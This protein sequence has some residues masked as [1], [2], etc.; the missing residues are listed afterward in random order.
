M[1]SSRT[2]TNNSENFIAGLSAIYF[3]QILSSI[4]WK[5]FP[6]QMMKYVSNNYFVKQIFLIV[7]ILIS[8]EFLSED[9][10]APFSNKLTATLFLYL[11]VLIFPKQNL[12]FSMVESFLFFASFS[13]YYYD[14]RD[15][16]SGRD[17]ILK[18][19]VLIFLIVLVMG[20][21]FYYLKQKR[22][23]GEKFSYTEFLFG[24]P[25]GH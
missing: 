13:L 25:E 15:V 20:F 7:F 10:L 5:L 22:D 23:K 18:I 14:D 1:V 3:S 24:S 16:E 4:G 17:D 19:L 2:L 11:T 6:P 9:P 12:Y 8:V 21:V